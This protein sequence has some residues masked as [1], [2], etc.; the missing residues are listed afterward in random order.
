MDE[1]ISY[2]RRYRAGDTVALSI[3]GTTDT[4]TVVLGEL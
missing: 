1:L 2:L 4:V 3:S